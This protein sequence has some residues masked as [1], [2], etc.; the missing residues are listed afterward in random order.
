MKTMI[1]IPLIRSALTS[2]ITLAALAITATLTTAQ[3]PGPQVRP[4]I[5]V[6]APVVAITHAK[7]IDGTGVPA[8]EGVTVVLK[9]SRIEAMGPDGSVSI[10]EG[11]EVLDLSG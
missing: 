7:V 8:R 10:P 6:D 9:D 1:S 5:A 11:A 2:A 4:F 3:E